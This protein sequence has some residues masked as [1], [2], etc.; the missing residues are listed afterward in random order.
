MAK[1]PERR[2]TFEVTISRPQGVLLLDIKQY[3]TDAIK[4]WSGAYD[5]DDP[6]HG[7]VVKKIKRIENGR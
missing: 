3:I 7:I 2:E 1:V 5:P 4:G 6:R